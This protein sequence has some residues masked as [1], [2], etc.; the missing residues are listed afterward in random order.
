MDEDFREDRCTASKSK[1]TLSVLWKVAYN[2]I[3]LMQ[4]DSPKDREQVIDVINEITD[5]ISI[6]MKWIFDLVPSF[7]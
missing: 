1:D 7:Y 6:I 3:R 5:D 2:I 4:M